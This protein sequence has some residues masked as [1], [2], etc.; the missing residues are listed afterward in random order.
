MAVDNRV[1]FLVREEVQKVLAEADLEAGELR[2]D[3]GLISRLDEL[4][5]EL[6]A[7]A[8]RVTELENRLKDLLTEAPE[9]EP[10]TRAR[11]TVGG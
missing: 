5:T 8:T 2:E 10:R 7:L 11:K 9:P 3:P 4:H 6:H 1:R